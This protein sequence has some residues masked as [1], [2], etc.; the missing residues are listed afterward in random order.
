MDGFWEGVQY[1]NQKNNKSVK[2]LGWDEKKQKG[3]TFSNSFTD[4]NKGKQITQTFV[5]QGADSSSRSPAAPGSGP[6]RRR[7][8]PTASSRDLGRHGRLHQRTAVLLGVPDQ[9]DQGSDQLGDQVR[10]RGCRWRQLGGKNF[11]GTLANGGTGLAPFHDFDS[12]VPAALKAQL[13]AVSQ[14]RI[15]SGDIKITSPSQPKLVGRARSRSGVTGARTAGDHQAVRGTGRQRPHRPRRRAW[16]D[17]CAARRERRR[18][19]HAD[20]RALRA[21]RARTRAR[22]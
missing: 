22:S 9:R 6:G 19:E 17:P 15:Q 21:L 1:Y 8:R 13:A 12:K 4:L 16:R 2:V 14:G 3:G 18:Q 5:G 7:S 20:E 11:I 10:R